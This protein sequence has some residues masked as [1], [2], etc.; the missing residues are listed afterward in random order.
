MSCVL[1]VGRMTGGG[2]GMGPAGSV[3]AEADLARQRVAARKMS[4]AGGNNCKCQG[5]VKVWAAWPVTASDHK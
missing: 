4:P 2:A 5:K 3:A 1:V